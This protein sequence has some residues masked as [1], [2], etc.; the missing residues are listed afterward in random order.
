MKTDDKL[1]R[2]LDMVEHPEQYTEDEIK[3]LLDDDEC[4]EYYELM[5]KTDGA[6]AGSSKPDVEHALR[7]FERKR[8]HTFSWRKM[9]AIFIGILVITGLAYAAITIT[10]PSSVSS[11]KAGTTSEGTVTK[12]AA[13]KNNAQSAD[14]TTVNEKVFDEV[15]LQSILDEVAAFYQLKVVY[16]SDASKHLRLHY[17]WDKTQDIETVIE[18]LNHFEKVNLTLADGIIQVK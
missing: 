6:C 10:R 5:V 8:E 1:E 2:L 16:L 3:E 15:E 4:R 9:A 13:E 12:R 17:S 18:T 7:A 11:P 14:T